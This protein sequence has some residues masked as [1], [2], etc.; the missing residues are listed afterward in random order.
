MANNLIDTYVFTS[1]VPKKLKWLG[2]F[3]AKS[4][5][6]DTS[7]EVAMRLTLFKGKA[8]TFSWG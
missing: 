4:Q 5:S 3:F 8:M 1:I 2:N 6:K 7:H